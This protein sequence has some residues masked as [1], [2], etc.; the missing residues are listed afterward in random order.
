MAPGNR[1]WSWPTCMGRRPPVVASPRQILRRQ[2]ER[3][4]ERG[5]SAN[6]GTEL[7]FIVFR[8][9]RGSVARGYRDLEPA[10]LYNVDYSL[11]GTA[12]IEPLIRRIRNEMAAPGCS[13]RA[14]RASATSAS[15]RS[16]SATPTA[17]A[18]ADNHVIYK[19]GAKEIAAQEGCSHL[20]G[21]A[22]R[23]RG[24]LTATS[25]ARSP[26]A[27]G[28]TVFAERR[29]TVPPLHRRPAR[30]HARDDAVLR[31]QRQLLQAVRRRARS[32]RPRCLGRRQPD[33]RDAGRRPRLTRFESRTGCPAPTSTRTW[34]WR[35]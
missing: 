24:Q 35:R 18:T 25:T 5:W 26:T 2:L 9:L 14:R 16:T 1:R 23:P 8:R 21:E 27:S 6:A 34:R 11:L 3:L 30:L 20:H 28:R 19:N 17:L 7:E 10:N 4:A 12:R 22:Q 33:L 32:R 15:T 29:A 31:A 13:S